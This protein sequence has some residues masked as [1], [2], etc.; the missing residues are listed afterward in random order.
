LKN[1]TVIPKTPLVFLWEI[2]GWGF[3]GKKF[4]GFLFEK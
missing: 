2:R 1:N 4:S 3:V